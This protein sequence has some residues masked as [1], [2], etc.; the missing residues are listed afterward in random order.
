PAEVV[1]Q[2]YP[3]AVERQSLRRGSGGAG[4]HRGG[5]GL[6]RIYRCLADELSLTTMFERRVVLPYGL[7]G[8]EPGAGF[9][10]T[11][12]RAD[13]ETRE[14]TGRAHELLKTGDRVIL[15]SCGGG[16]WGEPDPTKTQETNP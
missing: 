12:E 5:E 14:L 1:E 4:R 6:V 11:L 8:G 10:V 15:E 16:G 13:G 2:D 9:H 3:L 7:A